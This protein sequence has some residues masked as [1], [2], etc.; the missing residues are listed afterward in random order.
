MAI[1]AERLEQLHDP[2]SH[3]LSAAG[4]CTIFGLSLREFARAID[5]SESTVKNDPDSP[6]LQPKLN[7]LALAYENLHTT[8]SDQHIPKWMR[9]PMKRLE[10]RT[11]LA[12]MSEFG[13]EPFFQLTEEIAGDTYS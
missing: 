5:E 12:Y 6:K 4:F 8:Y 2:K 13:V 3:R 10:G 9:H 7:S 1:T 11:P